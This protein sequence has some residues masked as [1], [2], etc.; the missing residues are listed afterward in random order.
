MTTNRSI[1]ILLF[2]VM[3]VSSSVMV[4]TA[5]DDNRTKPSRSI[6][7]S[8]SELDYPPF[9]I[10][11]EDGSAD[12]FSVDLLK[13]VVK[14]VGLNIEFTVGPWAEIKQEL[15]DGHI[16]VL[17]LVSYS[18]EREK[19]YDFTAPYLRMNGTFFIRQGEKPIKSEADLKGK[20]ILVM[21]GDTAHEYAVKKNLSDKMI[22]TDSFEEA[23]RLLSDGKHDAVIIQK[24]VGLQLINKLNVSN[25]VSVDNIAEVNLKPTAK[26]LSGF[27]QK[28]CIATQD[29][30]RELQALLNEGLAIV[31]ANGTYNDLY[32]KWFGP[33][34]PK[35]SVPFS[36]ILKYLAFILAPILFFLAAVGIWYL[37]KK[38]P[39]KPMV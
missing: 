24:L 31:I 5:K 25:L 21:R 32:D 9:A 22:L 35:P 30:D 8:A 17:P 23:M 39:G 26:P 20:E 12:G 36:S 27:E 34:L 13:S 4:C 11:R 7:K 16:D 14:A 28:F 29:D 37:K 15:V 38:W 6:L 10:V 33:I 19:V 18:I 2:V 3:T 1:F